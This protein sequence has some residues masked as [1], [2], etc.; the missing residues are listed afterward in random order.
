MSLA[1][2]GNSD[3]GVPTPGVDP[4]ERPG[5][6]DP[7][8]PGTPPA[9][10][11]LPTAVPTSEPTREEATDTV[12][13]T[14]EPTVEEA[15]DTAEPDSTDVSPPG[16]PSPTP[17]STPPLATATPDEGE[18]TSPPDS[19][20]PTL[21]T[22]DDG[23]P[24]STPSGGTSPVEGT[25]SPDNSETPAGP[26]PTRVPTATPQPTDPPTPTPIPDHDGD[27]YP[28]G[29]DCND[30]NVD[31]HP[32]VTELPDTIDQDCDGVVDEGTTNYDDDNDGSSEAQGDCDDTTS[33]VGPSSNEIA[34]G[35]DNNCNGQVDEGTTLYDDDDDGFT[36]AAG[37]CDDGDGAIY[38]GAAEIVDGQ[39]NDCDGKVDEGSG[40]YDDDED[41]V[42]DA[43]GDCDDTDNTVYPG[44]T[45]FVDGQDNNCDGEVDEGTEVYDDDGDGVTEEEGDCDDNSTAVVPGQATCPWDVGGYDCSDILY[46]GKSEG[47]AYDSITPRGESSS[48]AVY[49]DM[50]TDGGGWTL[51]G[52]LSGSDGDR[53]NLEGDI[54]ADDTA[55]GDLKTPFDRDFKSP[56][57][58]RMTVSYGEVMWQRRYAGV[59]RSRAVIPG[60]AINNTPHFK[61]LFSAV[62]VGVAS[63]PADIEVLEASSVG[64]ASGSYT[65]GES[66]GLGGSGTNGFCWF[67]ED[68]ND[69]VFR[70]HLHWNQYPGQDCREDG[71]LGGVGVYWENHSQFTPADITGTNWLN[72]TDYT[73]TDINLF[74]RTP[75]PGDQDSDG[76]TLD[77]GDC[78]DLDHTIYPGSYSC[79]ITAN[80][81]SCAEILYHGESQGTGFYTLKPSSG[82]PYVV[83]CD[84]DTDGGGWTLL[85]TVSGA[86]GD[87]WNV[88]YGYWKDG[89]LLGSL[90]SP[91]DRD[92]KSPAWVEMDVALSEVLF[93]RRYDGVTR[94][95]VVLPGKVIGNKTLFTQQFTTRDYTLGARASELR[96]LKSS[97]TGV[98]TV[99]YAEGATYGLGGSGT[100]GFCW[101][102]EDT[103]DNVF[104]GHLH[105]NQ[106]P[107]ADCQE[108]GHAGGVALYYENH[109]QYTAVD[110]TGTN[111]LNGTNYAKTAINL[112]VRQFPSH[113]RDGDG[114][115][116][117]QDCDD[118][119]SAIYPGTAGC[120]FDVG[121]TTC[122]D[123]KSGGLDQGNGIYLIRPTGGSP[124]EVFCDMTTDGGGWTL[125]GTLSGADSSQWNMEFGVWSDTTTLGSLSNPFAA[126]YKSPLWATYDITSATLM[127]ERRYNNTVQGQSVLANTCLKGKTRFKDLFTTRDQTLACA[128]TSIRTVKSSSTGV[129]SSSY[130][131]GASSGLGGSGTNGFCWFGEDTEDNVFRGHLHWNQYPGSGCKMQGHL[132]GVGVYFANHSQ[133]TAS[134]I[135]GTNWLNGVTYS[136]VSISLYVK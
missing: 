3:P 126:D 8:V 89:N 70:G 46:Q 45:E 67:G 124:Y 53:W 81:V 92:Y 129:A 65:E 48:F 78:N 102:G 136:A 90:S 44:A 29:E 135:T 100:N 109:S 60:G 107:G 87:N 76:V 57:W 54:W 47:D 19:P 14:S 86:D 116:V 94:G 132:G 71:H 114:T 93:Q 105:W 61:D 25:A 133:F 112:F 123:I 95:Q 83:L 103:E 37:D 35:I 118:T 31:I 38:P 68:T 18:A 96:I 28:A 77:E 21:A 23:T 69:N 27:G 50:T 16:N 17:G 101:F 128:P 91:L 9:P 36:E 5:V 15:T 24:T 13:P 55:V 80:Q 79:P 84:M 22:P 99:D 56:A 20:S 131:E 72:G 52:T 32:G 85:G 75:P 125:L 82:D 12:E 121:G 41:G 130:A 111:W 62:D 58:S 2:C 40:V 119:N 104:R 115:S 63:L 6:T 64:V 1:G 43:E 42:T 7:E 49:C 106:Y 108:P 127:F 117:P 51:L 88:E 39:D 33:Q 30:N 10:T 134:D 11:P 110:I 98:A 73:K 26:T 122:K 4:T 97:S 34:D 66:S 120:G 113:D 59:V 74:V